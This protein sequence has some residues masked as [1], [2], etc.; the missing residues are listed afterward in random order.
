M[1]KQ[2]L[3]LKLVETVFIE[4]CRIS[5]VAIEFSLASS[6]F[7]LY[8]TPCVLALLH[9]FN[10]FN[11]SKKINNLQHVSFEIIVVHLFVEAILLYFLF[12]SLVSFMNF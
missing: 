4:C 6:G 11:L 12:C 10:L 2:L 1:K 8:S 3:L 5:K 7:V 9:Q